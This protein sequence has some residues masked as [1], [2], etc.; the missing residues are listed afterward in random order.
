MRTNTKNIG[1]QC[2]LVIAVQSQGEEATEEATCDCSAIT[3]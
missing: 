1:V 2:V 3:R